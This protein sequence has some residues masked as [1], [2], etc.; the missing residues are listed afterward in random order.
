MDNSMATYSYEKAQLF[1][2]SLEKVFSNEISDNFSSGY[3][4]FII[5]KLNVKTIIDLFH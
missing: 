2:C 3:E 1:G 5:K 4:Y